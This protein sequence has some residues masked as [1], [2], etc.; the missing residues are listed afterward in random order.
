MEFG[1]IL[2]GSRQWKNN[3][4]WKNIVNS[5]TLK[6]FWM[7]DRALKSF[8]A[9]NMWLTVVKTLWKTM[10][11]K[12]LL[13]LC[14]SWP[15][16][17]DHGKFQENIVTQPYIYIIYIYIDKCVCLYVWRSKINLPSK[18]CFGIWTLE[19]SQA[20]GP[21][22]KDASASSAKGNACHCDDA[23]LAPTP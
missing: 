5:D 14:L 13:Y 3:Q 6:C 10:F 7:S 2:A 20:L 19:L 21:W 12:D 8:L 16:A 23:Q 1:V 15:A 22:P 17:L 4:H 18:N 11:W 9:K